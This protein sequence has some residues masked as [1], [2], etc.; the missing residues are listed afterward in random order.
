MVGITRRQLKLEA[1]IPANRNDAD[2]W[3]WFCLM[4]EH[5]RLRWCTSGFG[6]SVS[7]DLIHFATESSFDAAIKAARER[8]ESGRRRSPDHGAIL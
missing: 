2:L 5:G 6:W 3:R 1:M 8:F 4:Y 7:V